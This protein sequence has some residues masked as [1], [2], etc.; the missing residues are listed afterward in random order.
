MPFFVFN[1]IGLHNLVIS[2]KEK[3]HYPEASGRKESRQSLSIIECDFSF[4]EM[5]E[6]TKK[7]NC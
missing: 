1:P 3:S 5:T 6:I 7:V 2:T 4:V